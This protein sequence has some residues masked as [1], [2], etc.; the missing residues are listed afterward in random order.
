[1][2]FRIIK[3]N[4]FTYPIHLKALECRSNAAPIARRNRRELSKFIESEKFTLI[5]KIQLKKSR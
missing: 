4:Y 3:R 5:F 1:M 2:T